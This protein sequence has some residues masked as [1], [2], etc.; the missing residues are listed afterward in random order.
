MDVK[1]VMESPG[2]WVAC[3]I[4]LIVVILQSALFLRAAWREA[5]RLGI[6]RQRRLAGVR[7]AVIT[8]FGP[9]L[10]PV[11]ILVA[12]ITMLGAPTSWMRVNDIGA[13]RTEIA[14]VTIASEHLGV[15]PGSPEYDLRAFSYSHWAMALNDMGWIVVALL[16]THRMAGITSSLNKKYDPRLIRYIMDGAGIGLFAYLLSGQLVP[17]TSHK[18][19]AALISGATMLLITK[20]FAKH[21]RMQELAL[22]LSMLAGM[23]GSTALVKLI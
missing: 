18:W 11:I 10:A 17:A 13:P 21:P 15:E 3:S 6:S 1:A 22:G 20:L 2:L 14:M 5:I 4:T 12:L 8:A 9:A 16:L 7:A 19:L 23:L